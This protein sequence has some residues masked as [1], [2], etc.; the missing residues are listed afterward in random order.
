[1]DAQTKEI[2]A[3]AQLPKLMR[4]IR[5]ALGL[6]QEKLGRLFGVSRQ[7]ISYYETGD[8]LPTIGT[9]DKWLDAVVSQIK[10]LRQDRKKLEKLERRRRKRKLVQSVDHN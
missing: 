5:V 10:D 9:L 6:S 1:M 8:M 4:V 7:S 2:I 3:R